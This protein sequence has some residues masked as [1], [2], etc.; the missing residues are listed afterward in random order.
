MS[1]QSRKEQEKQELRAKI[2]DAATSIILEEGYEKF[3]MRKLADRIEY[4]PTVIYSYFRDKADIVDQILLEN[5]RTCLK[6]VMDEIKKHKNKS[7]EE[8]FRRACICFVVTMT[9]NAPQIRAVMQSGWDLLKSDPQDVDSGVPVMEA[10]LR[11]GESAGEFRDITQYSAEIVAAALTG[12]IFHL[13]S[14][15]VSD[16]NCVK[17]MVEECADILLNGVRR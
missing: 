8:R 14:H 16:R 11:E 6:A 1:I 4:S 17:K 7:L 5:N 2:F 10:L 3:S 13:V 9:E 15:N 12:L